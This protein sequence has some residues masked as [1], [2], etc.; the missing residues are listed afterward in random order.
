MFFR[1]EIGTGESD[2]GDIRD[3]K[4]GTCDRVAVVC[5]HTHSEIL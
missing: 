2:P 5:D 3:V 4:V 1:V